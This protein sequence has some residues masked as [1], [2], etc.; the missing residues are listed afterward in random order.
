MIVIADDITGAA[1][2]AGI[3]SEQGFPVQLLCAGGDAVGCDVVAT[4]GV[5]VI[6]TDT[7]SMSE[8]EAV[9]E[10][11]RI[12]AL[13]P[14]IQGRGGAGSSSHLFKKTDSAL[15]GHVVAELKA[16]MEATGYERAVY[17]PANPSKGRI[18]RNGVYYIR[19]VRGQ[20]SEVKE[21][22][23]DETAFSY[24]PEFPARTSILRER[25]PDAEKKGIL[26]PDA[27][28]EEDIRN[29]IATYHDGKTLFAGAADLFSAMI[30]LECGQLNLT[31]EQSPC[32]VSASQEDSPPMRCDTLILCGSTQSKPL[33]LGIPIAPMPREIYDGSSDLSLW[34]T[35]VYEQEQHSLILTIPHTH[36]TG[37]EVAVHLRTMMAEMTKQLV[38]KHCPDRLVIEGSATAWAT[39]QALGWTEFTITAQLAPG[40]VQMRAANGTLVTLKPGSYPWNAATIYGQTATTTALPR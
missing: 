34:D 24:D 28:S 35:T 27:E 21:V 25:F 19:E 6:A 22:P 10:T 12:A 38:T 16:L 40:V 3:A 1:E 31:E 20:R 37:K 30:A 17:L 2:I 14:S 9:A 7:R 39:L 15:R 36:R 29:V 11:R 8:D 4:S 33:E 18:I 13:L 23:L 32:E 26:L 5:T